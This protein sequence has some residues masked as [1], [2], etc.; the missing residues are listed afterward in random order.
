MNRMRYT[1][2]W[3]FLVSTWNGE[4]AAAEQLISADSVLSW[5][6]TT[7]EEGIGADWENEFA[8][9][10]TQVMNFSTDSTEKLAAVNHLF[11]KLR[12][13]S[14][15][16]PENTFLNLDPACLGNGGVPSPTA[17]EHRFTRGHL[18]PSFSGI[19]SLRERNQGSVFWHLHFNGVARVLGCA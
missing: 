15:P 12:L 6:E 4:A 3:L 10:N 5:V 8:Q 1:I 16:V 14:T 18:C 2:V 11:P 7:L 19:S 17:K 9:M 13:V